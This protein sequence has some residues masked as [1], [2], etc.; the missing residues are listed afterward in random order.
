MRGRADDNNKAGSHPEPSSELDR[1]AQASSFEVTSQSSS[2]STLIWGKRPGSFGGF[3][4][5]LGS[6]SFTSNRAKGKAQK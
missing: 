6:G 1:I 5:G 2:S 4:A 3:D